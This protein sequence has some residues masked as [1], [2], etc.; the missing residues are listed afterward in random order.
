MTATPRTEADDRAS[1][2]PH[3]P[4][5]GGSGSWT[6]WAWGTALTAALG[7]ILAPA[8][9]AQPYP[10]DVPDGTPWI[11][12]TGWNTK[13]TMLRRGVRREKNK[14]I[15]ELLQMWYMYDHYSD[16]FARLLGSGD[17][18]DDMRLAGDFVPDW[19]LRPL[20]EG[21]LEVSGGELVSTITGTLFSPQDL[22]LVFAEVYGPDAGFSAYEHEQQATAVAEQ[23][24][25][26]ARAAL[27]SAA[28]HALLLEERNGVYLEPLMMQTR[29]ALPQTMGLEEIKAAA[30]VYIAQ[31]YVLLENALLV[32]ANLKATSGAVEAFSDAQHAIRTP[33]ELDA[34]QAALD[35]IVVPAAPELDLDN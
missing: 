23:G 3:H 8:S 9:Q 32:L 7:C 28:R 14:T 24:I 34:I 31:E 15:E 10:I 6:R 11:Q 4:V 27:R 13:D 26:M 22:D 1:Y 25:A 35:A 12:G 17:I 21:N 33:G 19:L 20:E 29:T 2:R 18:V 5:R 30:D 16:L